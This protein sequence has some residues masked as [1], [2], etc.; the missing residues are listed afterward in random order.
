MEGNFNIVDL[1]DIYCF[2][3]LGEM[4]SQLFDDEWLEVFEVFK[5]KIEDDGD[6]VF[7]D[8][9]YMLQNI[10]MVVLVLCLCVQVLFLVKLMI[11]CK[12]SNCFF[13]FLEYF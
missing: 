11:W 12:F 6:D 7:F 4:Y 8:M 9:F 1:S 2:I 5:F 13:F 10:L 3:R